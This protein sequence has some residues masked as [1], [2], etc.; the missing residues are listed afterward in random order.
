MQN[1]TTKRVSYYKNMTRFV[2]IL[3]FSPLSRG[4]KALLNIR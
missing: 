3:T 4:K 1:K 2:D